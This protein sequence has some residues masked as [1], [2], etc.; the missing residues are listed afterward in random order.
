M[1]RLFLAIIRFYQRFISPALGAH[2]RFEPSCSHYTAQAIERH[3]ALKGSI[4]GAWRILRCNPLTKAGQIDPVPE[5]GKWRAPDS[6]EPRE[7]E[8]E[9]S[10]RH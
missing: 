9:K 7:P 6:I 10:L 8:P 3:G 5:M 2:C 1:S 4:L